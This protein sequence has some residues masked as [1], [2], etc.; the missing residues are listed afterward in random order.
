M[1]ATVHKEVTHVEVKRMRGDTFE[2]QDFYRKL[3]R[4]LVDI[5]P[6]QPLET[7]QAVQDVET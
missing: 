7:V 4:Q 5:V 3:A 1:G 6:S 2:Y